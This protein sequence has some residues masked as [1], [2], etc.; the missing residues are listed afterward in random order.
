MC[1][2]LV[3]Q[4]K[5]SCV[6]AKDQLTCSDRVEQPQQP[7]RNC[8]LIIFGITGDLTKRLLYPAICNLGSQGLLDENFCIVGM[9]MKDYSTQTFRK[10]LASDINEFVVDADSKKYGLQLLNRVEYIKG[11]FDEIKAYNELDKKLHQLSEK[12][13]S[14]N[15]LFYFAIPPEFISTVATE[16]D[17][18]KLLIESEGIFRRII[19]EKPFGHD[20]A[21]AKLLNKE[22]L[23]IVDETQIFRI[24]HFLGK[25]TVQNLLAFRFSNGIFEPIWNG[26]YIDHVQITISETLGVELR[27]SYFE[28]AGALRDMIPSHLLQ[29]LS[30][31][32]MEPPVSF[33]AE[34]I[35]DEKSKVIHSIDAFTPERVLQN[36]VRG[37]YGGGKINQM[38]VIP[39][40]DEPNVD[41]NSATETYVAIKLL[42]DNWR[43]LHVP[44]YIRTGKRLKARTSEVII[45]FKSEPTILFGGNAQDIVP[46]I[47]CIKIQPDEGISLRFNAKKPG[48]SLQLRPV[49]MD[50]KYVDYFGV[51]PQTGYETVLYDCMNGDHTLFERAE[52]V[53]SS[54]ELVQPI[55]D[56]WS[57][58]PPRDFPNYASGTWGPKAGNDLIQRDGREW[59]IL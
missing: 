2:T 21:S 3:K 28:K 24:D 10:Q 23:S 15:Y 59:I 47:L 42:L 11:R 32:A 58:L 4:I 56:L 8:V 25:E 40:R 26:R 50:F 44:F 57:A 31:I 52:M 34:Y 49:N 5:G 38:D 17:K 45:Q 14:K 30:L 46:N 6:K 53:T 33:S 22:L 39:Y 48:Q 54:W 18:T 20:V 7:A 13:G 37:Q 41:P 12:K 29:I 27:G 36:A 55:L 1:T 35:Q 16:L 19:V 51:K 9:A 43:W